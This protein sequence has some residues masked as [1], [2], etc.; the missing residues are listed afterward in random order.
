MF[1]VGGW[2]AKRTWLRGE[3]REG[4]ERKGGVA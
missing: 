2:V 1:G 4:D 3:G